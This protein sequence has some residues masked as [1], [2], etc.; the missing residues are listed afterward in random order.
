MRDLDTIDSELR[1]L[2]AVRRSIHEHGGE[3]SSRLVDELLDER[4]TR[5][6]DRTMSGVAQTAIPADVERPTWA[7]VHVTANATMW[8]N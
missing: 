4:L 3:P 7:S 2:A 1:L 5:C 8:L 6:G